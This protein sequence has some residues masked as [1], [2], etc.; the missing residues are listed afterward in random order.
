MGV[1]L[2]LE[3]FGFED[4]IDKILVVDMQVV[5]TVVAVGDTIAVADIADIEDTVVE[6]VGV[7][8]IVVVFEKVNF[9]NEDYSVVVCCCHPLVLGFW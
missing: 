9:E 7:E 8:L 4:V 1:V 2:L 6:I 5:D 3:N